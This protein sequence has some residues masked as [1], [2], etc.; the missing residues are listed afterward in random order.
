[1]S[2]LAYTAYTQLQPDARIVTTEFFGLH[3]RQTTSNK[4]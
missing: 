4:G 3:L 1:M 2:V